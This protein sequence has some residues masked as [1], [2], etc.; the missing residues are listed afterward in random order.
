MSVYGEESAH[1]RRGKMMNRGA[2]KLLCW[3]IVM[4]FVKT[5]VW[6]RDVRETTLRFEEE[7]E[8][9]SSDLVGLRRNVYIFI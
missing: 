9:I 4:V 2:G 5:I 1:V 8:G 3:K 7:S 6:H